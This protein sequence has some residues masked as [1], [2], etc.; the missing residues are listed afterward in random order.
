MSTSPPHPFD[1]RACGRSLAYVT[2]QSDFTV[3]E[4]EDVQ[5]ALDKMRASESAVP[6]THPQQN[7]GGPEPMQQ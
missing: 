1:V 2:A 5:P 7:E 3:L 6:Q 4:N